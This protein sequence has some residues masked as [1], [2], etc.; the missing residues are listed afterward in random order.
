MKPHCYPVIAA[1]LCWV[2]TEDGTLL[3]L[4]VKNYQRP[5]GRQV[6]KPREYNSSFLYHHP[7]L[8]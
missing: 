7:T 2:A 3:A 5:Q 1:G 4:H 6:A 8:T